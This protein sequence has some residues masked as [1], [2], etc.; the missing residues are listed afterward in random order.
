M[1]KIKSLIWNWYACPEN[2][3]DFMIAT[4]G[5]HGCES[6]ELNQDRTHAVIT[7]DNRMIEVT[8]I[9]TIEWE[10]ENENV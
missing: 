6:I 5:R 3:C 7:Y 1:R 8:N 4:I 9:N 10:I 2:G